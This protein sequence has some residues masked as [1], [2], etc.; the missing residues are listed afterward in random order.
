MAHDTHQWRII[1]PLIKGE[2]KSLN[3]VS[4]PKVS[5]EHGWSVAASALGQKPFL[6]AGPG[7]FPFVYTRNAPVSINQTGSWNVRFEQA[8]NEYVNIISTVGILGLAAYLLLI[9][10]L[11]K[12]IFV[13]CAK[14]AMTK[15]NP[16]IIFLLASI[17]R[18]L[19]SS[20][21]NCFYFSVY[22]SRKGTS[23]KIWSKVS[24]FSRV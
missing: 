4:E 21:R 1:T 22:I 15:E 8:S 10:F 7:T 24:I 12:P 20:C 16:L 13:F 14:S 11:L 17:K 2:D 19:R 9:F 5:L 23:N 18:G 6:G 3:L